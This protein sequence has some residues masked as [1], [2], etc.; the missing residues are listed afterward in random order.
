MSYKDIKDT[1]I[2]IR[3]LVRGSN[4]DNKDLINFRDNHKEKEEKVII[5][6]SI[7]LSIN[8]NVNKSLDFNA[9]IQFEEGIKLDYKNEN[10][11]KFSNTAKKIS[12]NKIL[13]KE[14]IKESKFK[15]TNLDSKRS[16]NT[17]EG[18]LDELDEIK[19]KQ[20]L[21]TGEYQYNQYNKISSDN[22][23]TDN[24]IFTHDIVLTPKKDS[25]TKIT[26]KNENKLSS[27]HEHETIIQPGNNHN[28]AD[29][30][31]NISNKYLEEI[32]LSPLRT[33]EN[34]KEHMKTSEN[35]QESPI[36]TEGNNLLNENNDNNENLNTEENLKEKQTPNDNFISVD[37]D[38]DVDKGI[39]KDLN[40]S[41]SIDTN[42]HQVN[43]IEGLS[44]RQVN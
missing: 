30:N 40:I 36:R 12:D 16:N 39:D 24:L 7:E 37:V 31:K 33:N 29:N 42:H 21:N 15:E 5:N 38:V 11:N 9:P 10:F 26:E 35:L 2:N 20:Q 6:N 34:Q 27:R 13:F 4:K 43:P 14:L 28:N 3:D 23:I 25:N 32:K 1:E 22:L 17:K 18:N 8:N 41:E 44:N 19:F